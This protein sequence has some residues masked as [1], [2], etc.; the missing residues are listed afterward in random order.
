[1]LPGPPSGRPIF[2]GREVASRRYA[3]IRD[4]KIS[5]RAYTFASPTRL[6]R[7]VLRCSPPVSWE[8]MPHQTGEDSTP[9]GQACGD[10]R[11]L[12]STSA[13]GWK[14]PGPGRLPAPASAPHDLSPSLTARA[15]RYSNEPTPTNPDAHPTRATP[16]CADG[17]E[18]SV[19]SHRAA[20]HDV[21]ST[22]QEGE[23]NT[24]AHRLA[25]G[26]RRG[27]DRC[28]RP[29]E[30]DHGWS[31]VRPWRLRELGPLARLLEGADPRSCARDLGASCDLVRR[32]HRALAQRVEGLA[33]RTNGALF[34][35]PPRDPACHLA[36]HR[37]ELAP[38]HLCSHPRRGSWRRVSAT[39]W[40]RS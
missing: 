24:K 11:G 14:L 6:G 16:C 8:P 28:A 37:N 23:V 19:S 15:V 30:A 29:P 32:L 1:V 38:V 20:G 35:S 39:S 25:Y 33:S 27:G 12:P 18:T 2:L 9:K 31:A 13:D 22:P 34:S 3:S 21:H 10:A 26:L 40:V 5:L 17:S 4:S 36:S 7:R